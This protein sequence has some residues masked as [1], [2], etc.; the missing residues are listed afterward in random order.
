MGSR[1]YNPE[2]GRFINADDRIADIGDNLIGYNMFAYCF[3]NPIN[4]YDPTGSWPEWATL[5]LGIGLATVAVAATYAGDA[6]YQFVTGT[7]P[8]K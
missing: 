3:N 4:M 2:V 6:A 5:A 1:Y 8:I 7:S